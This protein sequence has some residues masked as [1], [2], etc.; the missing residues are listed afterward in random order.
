MTAVF[1]G[2]VESIR[3]DLA[4][5]LGG[6]MARAKSGSVPSGVGYGEVCPLSSRLG[7]LG[8]VVSSENGFLAYFEC[9]RT[10][11]LYLYDKI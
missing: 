4:G 9:P 2:C 7:S 8:S 1:R 11:C 5:I 3:V 6:L 10:L